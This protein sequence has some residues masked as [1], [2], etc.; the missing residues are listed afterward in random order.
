MMMMTRT[1]RRTTT[2]MESRNLTVWGRRKE[3]T[4]THADNQ[5]ESNPSPTTTNNTSSVL[6]IHLSTNLMKRKANPSKIANRV[7]ALVEPPSSHH[8]HRR[9]RG[10]AL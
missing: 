1:M 3:T 10:R 7:N 9:R 5:H 2:K 4:R 6:T 8:H